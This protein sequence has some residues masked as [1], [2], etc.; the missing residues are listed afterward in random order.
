M[1]LIQS[2]LIDSTLYKFCGSV[3]DGEHTWFCPLSEKFIARVKGHSVEAICSF[4]ASL[5]WN[6]RM[7]HGCVF[8]GTFIWLVPCDATAVVRIHYKTAKMDALTNWPPSFQLVDNAFY[9]GVFDGRFVWLLPYNAACIVKIDVTSCEMIA[10]PLPGYKPQSFF[11]GCFDGQKVWLAPWD[12][13]ELVWVDKDTSAVTK[14]TM[15]PYPPSS[16]FCGA[17]FDGTNVWLVPYCAPE[18]VRVM[19]DGSMK[20]FGIWPKN[21]Q[22]GKNAFVGGL[23]I[24]DD[25]VLLPFSSTS[26]VCVNKSNGSMRAFPHGGV[27]DTG[28]FFFGGTWDGSRLLLAPSHASSI[29]TLE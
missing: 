6:G 29:V 24:G 26:V 19:S 8:D 9:D 17:V 28:G 10:V 21:F 15:K 22:K 2:P 23:C 25:V 5:K 11:S 12:A 1:V 4:P 7:F 18:P 13:K 14:Y 3:F 27:S 20:S 16:A